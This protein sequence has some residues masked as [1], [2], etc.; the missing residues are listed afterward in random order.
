MHLSYSIFFSLFLLI[1]VFS[2][3][4]SFPTVDVAVNPQPSLFL[5][6]YNQI[7]FQNTLKYASWY[8]QILKR[9]YLGHTKI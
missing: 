5:S 6:F 1:S 3:R 9:N 2:D 7:S 4:F 8:L